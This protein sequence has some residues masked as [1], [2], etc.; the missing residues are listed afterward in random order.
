MSIESLSSHSSRVLI[1][2]VDKSSANLKVR[3]FNNCFDDDYST[4]KY[5]AVSIEVFNKGS[6]YVY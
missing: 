6:L 4:R 3:Y 2:A 5:R 1:P